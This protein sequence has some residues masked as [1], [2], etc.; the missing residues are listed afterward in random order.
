MRSPK[1]SI[2]LACLLCLLPLSSYSQS[3]KAGKVSRIFADSQHAGGAINAARLA[4]PQN[5]AAKITLTYIGDPFI[6][7]NTPDTLFVSWKEKFRICQIYYATRPGGGDPARYKNAVPDTGSGELAITRGLQ[8]LGV[9]IYYCI[10]RDV[11]DPAASS[12]EFVI[13]V[14]PQVPV[15]MLGPI[16]EFTQQQ[17]APVFRWEEIPGVPYYYIMLTQG[18]LEILTNSETGKI[19]SLVG[20]NLIWQ[21]FTANNTIQYGDTDLSGT[22]PVQ[23][24]PPLLPGET[25][26]WIVF[27]AFGPDFKYIAW[28]LYPLKPSEFVL[29]RQALPAVPAILEPQPN[30]VTAGEQ[31]AFRWR[32]VP[33][34]ERYHLLLFEQ[35]N[36]D[37]L[38]DGTLLL[39]QH[40][41]PDSQANFPAAQFLAQSAY[42]LQVVA[43]NPA[44][45]SASART[46][47][48]YQPVAGRL[49]LRTLEQDSDFPV[50]YAE[51]RI[52]RRS[53]AALPFTFF[54]DNN[55]NLD[56]ELPHGDYDV[57]VSAPGYLPS[58]LH[59]TVAPG[60]IFAQKVLLAPA[61]YLLTGRVVDKAGQAIP[62]ARVMAA[63]DA[64]TVVETDGLGGFTLGDAS[65]PKALQFTAPGFQSKTVANLDFQGMAALHLGDIKLDAATAAVEGTLR[66]ATGLPVAGVTFRLTGGGQEFVAAQ[67]AS[68]HYHMML[69]SGSWAITPEYPGYYAQPPAYTLTLQPGR[70]RQ[71]PFVFYRAAFLYGGVFIGDEPVRGSRLSLISHAD[72]RKHETRTDNFG[73]FRFDVPEGGY[74]LRSQE[75]GFA[76]IEREVALVQGESRE[77]DLTL[78]RQKLIWGE[79]RDGESDAGLADVRIIDTA[80][81]D[82][83][84][85][86]DTQGRYAFTAED[87]STFL[88]D[89]ELAGYSSQGP[90]PVQMPVNQDSLRV[91]FLLFPA[92]G[93]VRGVVRTPGGAPVSGAVVR[94]RDTAMSA[95]TDG[96]GEFQ[97]SLPAGDYL[98][99]AQAG[100][101]RSQETAVSVRLGSSQ[102]LQLTLQGNAAAVSGHVYDEH[103][104]P[105]AGASLLAAG[106]QTFNGRTDSTGAYTMCIEPGV[107]LLLASL[108]GYLPAD[109]TLVLMADD[110]LSGVDFYLPENFARIDG[111]IE[112][113]SG[114]PVA[115]ALIVLTNAWQQL[116][117]TSD[118]AGRFVFEKVIPG[119][120]TL[121]VRAEGFFSPPV[122]VTLRGRET[123]ALTIQMLESTGIISGRV[124]DGATGQGIDSVVVNAQVPGT[125]LFFTTMSA[126]PDGAFQLENLPVVQGQLFRLFATKSGYVQLAPVDSIPANT[127]NVM[128]SMLSNRAV[129]SGE[130]HAADTGNPI[131]GAALS[132]GREG[133]QLATAQSDSGGAFHFDN[134]IA[135]FEYQVTVMHSFFYADSQKI[136]APAKGRLFSLRR[137]L[138]HLSGRVADAADSSGFGDVQVIF[139]NL[140]GDGS[141]TTQT[142]AVGR[143]ARD[144][145][146]GR[147]Q[148]F[149]E[150]PLYIAQPAQ[151]LV[152]VAPLDTL[153]HLDFYLEKQVLQRLSIQGPAEIANTDSPVRYTVF[154]IDSAGRAITSVP[155]IAWWADPAADTAAIDSLGWLQVN[156]RYIG[157]VLV[158]A[159]DRATGVFDTLTVEVGAEL[160]SLAS[161]TYFGREGQELTIEAGA[162]AG[163]V[164]LGFKLGVLSPVQKVENAFRV[165]PPLYRL[166]P[167]NFA[168]SRPV[169]LSLPLQP[170]VSAEQAAILR[171]DKLLSRWEKAQEGA[172]DA[173]R[174]RLAR[175]I[176]KTGDFAVVEFSRPLSIESLELQP[177][178]FSPERENEFGERGVAIKF[179]V[180]SNKAALPLVSAQIF[181]LEGNLVATLADQLPVPKGAQHFS[182][183]GMTTTGQLA[184]NGRY[185][186][187]FRVQDGVDSK[188]AL[189]SLVLVQ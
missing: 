24:A 176:E 91:D 148:L 78:E 97:F 39:W 64:E 189:R 169:T 11:M 76:P 130:V 50:R 75:P 114:V 163:Q 12:I 68:G 2:L 30:S 53:G 88:L 159:M 74:T 13:F 96:E 18:E 102:S 60:F 7:R 21:A 54:T 149:V 87:G 186:L 126:G 138:A 100:C 17:E 83:L 146:P 129:I 158:G 173:D 43:E 160:D 116:A 1:I 62:F 121:I 94:V 57:R 49:Y 171:W 48:T 140:D 81:G 15:R 164:R 162:V 98:L 58:E 85:R 10:L 115:D 156:P 152:Q 63:G 170:E 34:A 20:V 8:Q 42:T 141:D 119:E 86:T 147:Y 184:R 137:K 188:Q 66:D 69:E 143:F 157:T 133:E 187:Q 29:Q 25:Y 161:G 105:L 31:I 123:R 55:A 150:Q 106:V 5:A 19:D 153:R 124:V 67:G 47:F 166:T 16:G 127:E 71:A 6:T 45:V 33:G 111:K 112:S 155:Q 35:Q 104:T 110:S 107:Y 77:I 132:L 22:W 101:L 134:L 128:L 139:L 151:R 99:Q 145:R 52:E 32:R 26:N 80:T 178:P 135:T 93:I 70:K 4:S 73:L 174:G 108:A 38:S 168:F 23:Y 182:W 109:T 175:K 177:N 36:D 154:A 44:A 61:E 3:A 9:G 185:I 84:A 40:V 14:Q 92:S 56:L 165:L 41:T 167:D 37:R 27:N 46:K 90:K 113:T 59:A 103:G 72:G 125:S 131:A 142:D 118:A 122:Q 179:V 180:T 120:A 95:V 79:V 172:Y 51:V 82:E 183:D 65:P 117:T 89:A 28:D 144:V 136:A 181:N